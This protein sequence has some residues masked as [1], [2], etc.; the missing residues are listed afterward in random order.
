[1]SMNFWSLSAAFYEHHPYP[2]AIEGDIHNEQWSFSNPGISTLGGDV[3]VKAKDGISVALSWENVVLPSSCGVISGIS[4]ACL[5]N[6]GEGDGNAET[7]C[8]Y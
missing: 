8:F 6:G 1:M 5:K 2:V 7:F 4:Y 3:V